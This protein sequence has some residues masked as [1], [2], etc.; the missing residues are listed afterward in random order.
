M[1]ESGARPAFTLHTLQ[2]LRDMRH[3]EQPSFAALPPPGAAASSC[4]ASW[5]ERLLLTVSAPC[6]YRHVADLAMHLP[7]AQHASRAAGC[8]L[9][10]INGRVQEKVQLTQHVGVGG[11]V[12]ACCAD[13]YLAGRRC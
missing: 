13:A 9:K 11:M 4:L 1:V 6:S 10:P 5:G 12:P 8:T 3:L 7:P 2:P